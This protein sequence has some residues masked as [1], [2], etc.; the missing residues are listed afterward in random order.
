MKKSI[1]N[2]RQIIITL[3]LLG[4]VG[5]ATIS[6]HLSNVHLALT[7]IIGVLHI[8]IGYQLSEKKVK[9]TS[10]SPLSYAYIF[11]FGVNAIVSFAFAWWFSGIVWVFNLCIYAAANNQKQETTEQE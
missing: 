5:G 11:T 10:D 9:P 4:V 3:I 6:P 2:L 1:G 7:I 8:Y